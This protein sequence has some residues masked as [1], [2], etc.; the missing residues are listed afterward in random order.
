MS[1]RLR[2]KLNPAPTG[3]ARVAA[4]PRGSTLRDASGVRYATVDAIG[5]RDSG[6]WYWV[7]G[8]GSGVP[9]MNTCD[10]PV[11]TVEEAKDAA[12]AYVR[13]ALPQPAAKGAEG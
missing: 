4:G 9:N 5:R 3:L 8:W 13:A 12:M 1:A 6:P 7:A 11:A 10:H 2:W